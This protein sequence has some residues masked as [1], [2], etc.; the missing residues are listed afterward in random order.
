MA[1]VA[2]SMATKARHR[3][4]EE[5]G[6]RTLAP[7]TTARGTRGRRRGRPCASRPGA[8]S[9][10]SAPRTSGASAGSTPTALSVTEKQDDQPDPVVEE[11][12]PDAPILSDEEDEKLYPGYVRQ[13]NEEHATNEDYIPIEFSNTNEDERQEDHD[14]GDFE[15][16]DED[17]PVM[18]YDRDN[19][20]IEEGVVFSEAVDCRNAAGTF[21][22][23]SETEYITLKSDQSRFTVKCAYDR[24]DHPTKNEPAI[25]EVQDE[26]QP[27][28]DVVQHEMPPPKEPSHEASTQASVVSPSKNYKKA[29]DRGASPRCVKEKRG[30]DV[31]PATTFSPTGSSVDSKVVPTAS[32]GLA[33]NQVPL[34]G[35]NT[36]R[37]TRSKAREAPNLARNT[38]SKKLKL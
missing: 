24:Y 10:P 30:G 15:N 23:K 3:E 21:S 1:A 20:S 35:P 26:D 19:P 13:N 6:V 9:T 33:P 32:K 38:R 28:P 12:L 27:I 36:A 16:A 31:Q 7:R 34:T 14:M 37:N 8:S 5:K 18:M 22:I 25:V 2:S 29:A 4:R 17:I 11:A